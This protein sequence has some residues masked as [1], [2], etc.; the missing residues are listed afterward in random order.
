MDLLLPAATGDQPWTL[1]ELEFYRYAASD[2]THAAAEAGD[3]QAAQ[4]VPK[5]EPLPAGNIWDLRPAP[6]HA[7]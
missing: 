4:A 5:L 6:Q 3:R 1:P 2:I 7:F